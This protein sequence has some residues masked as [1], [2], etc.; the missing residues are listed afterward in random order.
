MKNKKNKII[1]AYSKLEAFDKRRKERKLKEK[2]KKGRKYSKNQSKTVYVWREWTSVIIC[3]AHVLSTLSLCGALYW[4]LQWKCNKFISMALINFN[5]QHLMCVWVVAYFVQSLVGTV[6]SVMN[7]KEKTIRNVHL[8]DY[9]HT[10]HCWQ[11]LILFFLSLWPLL[12]IR[13]HLNHTTIRQ[14]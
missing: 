11:F 6:W 12:H 14:M 4:F 9:V 13:F 2:R 10:R 1:A 5:R 3:L 8:K 7:I